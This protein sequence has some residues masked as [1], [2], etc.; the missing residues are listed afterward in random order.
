MPPCVARHANSVRQGSPVAVTVVLLVIL[1]VVV[2]HQA[3]V[4]RQ[5]C[6]A[7]QHSNSTQCE[8][9]WLGLAG[10]GRWCTRLSQLQQLM[11]RRGNQHVYMVLMQLPRQAT[12]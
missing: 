2:L 1:K 9:R 7:L 6:G 12:Q 5:V 10:D 4:L 8:P 11:D 3:A